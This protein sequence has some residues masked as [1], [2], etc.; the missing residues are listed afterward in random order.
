MY[1]F[2]ASKPVISSRRFQ[3][4]VIV[5]GVSML[6]IQLEEVN[7]QTRRCGRLKS[8]AN[9]SHTYIN[10]NGKKLAR[11][12]CDPGY[13]L[14]GGRA[15]VACNGRKWIDPI[16]FCYAKTCEPLALHPNL[17]YELKTPGGL[18]QALRCYPG[19]TFKGS[20]TIFCDGH[21]WNASSPFCRA[22]FYDLPYTCTFENNDCY[23]DQ[24]PQATFRWLK[25]SGSTPTPGT[26]PNKDHTGIPNGH[27]L[28]VETSSEGSSYRKANLY[29]PML[30]GDPGFPA[31]QLR[32]FNFWYHMRGAT[33]GN[34]SVL[35]R[36]DKYTLEEAILVHR[37]ESAQGNDWLK[38]Q[39]TLPITKLDYQIILQSEPAV[40]IEG[41]TALDDIAILPK[42]IKPG[43]AD[44]NIIDKIPVEFL[45]T[46]EATTMTPET[47]TTSVMST[48]ATPG[49]VKNGVTTIPTI[50]TTAD[51]VT[52][53]L[54]SII[55]GA[56]D[57]ATES[58]DSI[59]HIVEYAFNPF[60]GGDEVSASPVGADRSSTLE[61]R[62]STSIEPVASTKAPPLVTYS[63]PTGV[64]S[65]L[66]N[67]SSVSH[68]STSS[69]NITTK[70][71]LA[72]FTRKPS[73]IT[74][75]SAS[76][77]SLEK[78]DNF[79]TNANATAA[80]VTS[81]AKLRHLN[82]ARA[83]TRPKLAVPLPAPPPSMHADNEK[84]HSPLLTA[85]LACLALILATI[86]GSVC[87]VV[88]VRRNRGDSFFILTNSEPE[89]VMDYMTPRP[90]PEGM[91]E[92][93][94]PEHIARNSRILSSHT[95]LFPPTAL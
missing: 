74:E 8:I 54:T 1:C 9:G 32:C 90:N 25:H 60:Y 7:G 20:T 66:A 88:I 83:P 75:A 82:I 45:L 27:Y 29:S 6:A 30:M 71:F 94:R 63:S 81:S 50:I 31:G 4:Y 89:L 78:F 84:F 21:Q 64:T 72:F 40:G 77:T 48:M 62:S 19:Y 18:L 28:Y 87:V 51:A 80:M 2:G 61:P 13:E 47:I 52:I 35:I 37:V 44:V 14:D 41:D 12:S 39:T 38:F 56:A 49:V 17:M 46:E 11:F 24:D 58:D 70:S 92:P 15:T 76:S 69:L 68:G 43:E 91:I 55:P 23:W 59:L 67:V 16:P 22:R 79:T 34:L 86:I 57:N 26:G 10:R 53:E 36:F 65:V 5:L 73:A 42:C 93:I 33:T 85:S 3:L 95:K